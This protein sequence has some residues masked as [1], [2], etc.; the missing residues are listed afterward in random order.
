LVEEPT[1]KHKHRPSETEWKELKE[2]LGT[3]IG[4]FSYLSGPTDILRECDRLISFTWAM[5]VNKNPENEKE[6]YE[7]YQKF[8][9][10]WNAALEVYEEHS[11]GWKDSWKSCSEINDDIFVIMLR[12]GLVTLN[13][14]IFNVSRAFPDREEEPRR[15]KRGEDAED[16]GGVDED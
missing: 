1:E 11:G 5:L 14:S 3:Y 16:G 6:Y 13:K 10:N 8:R 9:T 12:E 2:M 4:R 7:E 15:R